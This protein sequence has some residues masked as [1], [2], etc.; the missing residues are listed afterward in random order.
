MVSKLLL[1]TAAAVLAIAPAHAIELTCSAPTILVGKQSKDAH[2]TVVGI[3]IRYEEDC[4]WNSRHRM[5]NSSEV[6]REA[7]YD[8][9]DNS[10]RN[11]TQ[12]RG[13]LKR[14]PSQTMIGEIKQDKRGNFYYIEWFYFRGDL[15]FNTVSKCRDADDDALRPVPAHREPEPAKEWPSWLRQ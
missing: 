2:D 13:V 5:G 1:A 10:G 14:N 7:Q 15:R 4:E 12:W 6:R 9:R 8:L 3:D 11:L